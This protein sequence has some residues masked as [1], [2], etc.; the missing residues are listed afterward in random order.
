VLQRD[1]DFSACTLNNVSGSAFGCGG[2]LTST[3]AVFFLNGPGTPICT[4]NDGCTFGAD[5]VLRTV[6]A[7]TDLFNFGP[8]NYSQRPDR[9]YTAGVFANFDVSENTEAYAELMFMDDRS[10][11]QIAPSGS[12]LALQQVNC[13]NP[14]LSPS[15]VQQ[16]CINQGQNDPAGNAGIFIGRRNLEGGGRQD[17]IGHESYRIITGLRG[18]ISDNWSYDGYL[19]HG[20]TQRNSTFMNDFS[21]ARTGRALQ[22]RIDNRVNAMGQPVN[23]AT[24]GTAQC[25]SFLDGS[26]PNCVP[27]NIFQNG[28]V[29]PAALSY[30]QTP[31]VIRAQARQD[32]AHIDFT[33]NLSQFV[34]LP[35]A[36]TGLQINVGA[37]Y[38]DEKTEFTPDSQFQTGDLAGQG[39]A[40]AAVTGRFDVM[41]AFIEARIPLVEGKTAAKSI[42]FETAYRYSDYSVDFT[43]DTYKVG[44]DWEP[45]D[46]VRFRSSFQ[47]AVRAPN[48]GEIFSSNTVNLD[49]STDPC[50]GVIANPTAPVGQQVLESGRSLAECARSGVTPTQFGRIAENPAGQYNGLL[51]GNLNAKPEKADTVSFGVVYKADFANLTVAVDYFDIEIEDTLTSVIGGNA[52][53]YI[54]ECLNTGN[55]AFCN[56]VN[57][58]AQGSLFR[59][60]AGFIADT[61]SNIGVLQTTG[62][63]VQANYSLDIGVGTLG[64]ALT[65]TYLD[66]LS[67]EPISNGDSF[68]CRGLYGNQCGVPAPKW[69]SSL[70]T[71][72]AS[73]WGLDVNVTWRYFDPVKSERTSSDDQ[74]AGRFSTTDD[75][76]SSRSYF[77]LV[78]VKTF[79]DQY[80]FRFGANNLFDKDPPIVGSGGARGNCPTG[81]CNGN[82]YPQVYD[83][84]GRQWFVSLTVDF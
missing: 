62:I 76:L 47:R 19:Q 28:G 54:N 46:S 81:A 64:F 38:R 24:F 79:K 36:D 35:T 78:A 51:G 44:L 34:K 41:E 16:F 20:I 17:D 65:G 70:R 74:L 1:F 2:S 83:S 45:I 6:D 63:D 60:T 48:V 31:G 11:L 26:D 9:R 3:P 21:I 33:G 80:T 29:T 67:T 50:A 13:D 4:D 8:F 30:L 12:F 39:G 23:A 37:E 71:S 53:T 5:G 42:S 57:R 27:Y 22:V 7:S 32:I 75:R 82:T 10:T 68:D 14:F 73:P 25:V 52:D 55:P 40:T 15:M 72:W 18:Q 84:L 66:E 58:D 49:G 69:R 43:T 61:V 59:T 56:R 77:D